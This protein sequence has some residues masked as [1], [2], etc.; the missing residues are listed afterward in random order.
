MSLLGMPW[1]VVN[2]GCE[3]L[4]ILEQR[5]V[6]QGI[7]DDKKAR[8]LADI[9]ATMF[10]PTFLQQRL[11]VPQD[12]YSVASTRAVFDRIAHASIM[13]LSTSRWAGAVGGGAC[14]GVAWRAA[15]ELS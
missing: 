1:V 14:A 5:L 12:M 7:A 8:V 11:F 3:M 13:R 9:A 4:Y 15:A 10:D 6:A 2:L